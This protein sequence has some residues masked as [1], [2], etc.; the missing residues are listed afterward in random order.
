MEGEPD[1]PTTT[2]FAHPLARWAL[3]LVLGLGCLAS[4][5]AYEGT[6]EKKTFRMDQLTTVGGKT[7]K[8]VRIGYETYGTLNAQGNNAIFIAHF[9]SGNSHAA[10]RYA[11][12]DAAPGYWD[13]IIGAGKAIDTDKYFVVAADTLVNLSPGA[14]NVVTTGPASINPDT[15][16]EYGMGFPI[17]TMR[18]FVNTQKALLD[19]LGVK[20]LQAVVG[21]SMGSLQAMEWAAAYPEMVERVIPVIPGGV[22]ANPY[23]I[24]TLNAWSAPILNDPKWNQGNY[25]GKE[26][27]LQGL[28]EALKL[29]TLSSRNYGWADTTFGRRWAAADKNP[30]DAWSHSFAI[31]DTLAKAASA[32][33]KQADANSFLYLARANQLFRVGQGATLA[34]GL[35]RIK[36]KILFIP[37]HSDLLL[38]PDYS[39]KATEQLKAQGNVVETFEIQGDGGHLDGVFLIGQAAEAIR[40]F[41]AR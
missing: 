37:A 40:S 4:S 23:L 41:L 2:P 27:P 19:S 33:A 36:A 31:E 12:G 9:F 34:E 20:K 7:I 13:S 8:D 17:V 11:P 3:T 1:M 15:G 35:Q 18:D 14:A 29:V 5:W 21:A 32:R 6:V 22:E 38:F 10:G 28:A 39:R 25:Y 26:A 30:L 16:K 24:E